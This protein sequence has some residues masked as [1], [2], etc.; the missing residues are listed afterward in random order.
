MMKIKIETEVNL[1]K[2]KM[3]SDRDQILMSKINS[4]NSK[5][6]IN[7]TTTSHRVNKMSVETTKTIE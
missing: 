2:T 1:V 4:N 6:K 5:T 3:D 7:N